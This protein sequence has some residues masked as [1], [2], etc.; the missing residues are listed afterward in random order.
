MKSVS[1]MTSSAVHLPATDA[2]VKGPAKVRRPEDEPRGR[3]VKPAMD[4]YVPEEKREPSGR[5]WL[6]RDEDGRPK[7]WF[8]DP[9]RTLDGP[10]R[11]DDVSDADGLPQDGGAKRPEKK[12]KEEERCTGNTDRVDREIEQL[13]KRR[14]EL[15]RLL[16]TETS[17]A[18]VKN[19][20]KQLA[21]VERELRQKDN[22]AYRRRNTVFS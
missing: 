17:E 10:G 14:E 6:G 18:N 15:K 22:D 12:G 2:C 9:E 1:G 11:P 16:H 4:E 8:D 19:L 5:Y 21:Q 3:P 13:K 7:I 20:E